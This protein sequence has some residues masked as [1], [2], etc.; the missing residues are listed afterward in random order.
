VPVVG[1]ASLPVLRA[2]WLEGTVLFAIAQPEPG[3]KL[4]LRIYIEQKH[5]DRAYQTLNMLLL[6]VDAEPQLR[7]EAC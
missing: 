4:R 3:A 7:A 2:D 5:V 1:Q 6:D